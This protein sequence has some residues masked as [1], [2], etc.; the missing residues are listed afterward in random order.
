MGI[1]HFKFQKESFITLPLVSLTSDWVLGLRGE[2]RS[3]TQE[4]QTRQDLQDVY[5]WDQKKKKKILYSNCW[6]SNSNNMGYFLF[7]N[8]FF[9]ITQ[10]ERHWLTHMVF[11]FFL[12]FFSQK[13]KWQ[14]YNHMASFFLFFFNI[15][16]QKLQVARDIAC[17]IV[18]KLGVMCGRWEWVS[19]LQGPRQNLSMCVTQSELVRTR[20][21]LSCNTIHYL[22]INS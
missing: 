17:I 8:I 3:L 21:T 7:F 20:S 22:L 9:Q 1:S 10:V 13:S 4:L 18:G 5:G 15:F 6:D 11:F 2:S 19:R 14:H 12:I 16:F